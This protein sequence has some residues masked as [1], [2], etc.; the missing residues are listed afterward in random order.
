MTRH[1]SN[2]EPLPLV[3]WAG[4]KNFPNYPGFGWR[5]LS[6]TTAL[7]QRYAGDYQVIWRGMTGRGMFDAAMKEAAN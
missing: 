3:P 1:L 4:A 7:A 2:L 5:P 6:A